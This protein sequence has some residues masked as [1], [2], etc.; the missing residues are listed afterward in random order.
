MR[1]SRQR[2]LGLAAAAAVHLLA[3]LALLPV[4]QLSLANRSAPSDVHAPLMIV[5]LIRPHWQDA[6]LAA[7]AQEAPLP[8]SP[9]PK[10]ISLPEQPAPFDV[11]LSDPEAP[12]PVATSRL[13]DDDPLYRAPYRDAIAHA[14]S[15]LRAGLDCAH[16]DLRDLP[17]SLLDLCEAAERARREHG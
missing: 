15:R 8:D 1:R 9:Q 2:A 7:A 3:A 5:Q 6:R 13:E 4:A 12:S 17:K 10:S 16:V 11:A 14:D